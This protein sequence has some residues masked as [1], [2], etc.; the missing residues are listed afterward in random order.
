MRVVALL[1]FEGLPSSLPK[2]G[3]KAL[4]WLE[5]HW[6]P[7][8]MQKNI[9]S[10]GNIFLCLNLTLR[11]DLGLSSFASHERFLGQQKKI[12]QHSAWLLRFLYGRLDG[13]CA[14]STDDVLVV[15]RWVV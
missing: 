8:R 13:M 9:P 6:G 11:Q 12:Y 7:V 1:C 4:F 2:V 14:P 5:A 15:S 3:L 10:D